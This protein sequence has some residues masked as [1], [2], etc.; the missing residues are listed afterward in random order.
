MTEEEARKKWCPMARCS[1][2]EGRG[3]FNRDDFKLNIMESCLASDC[4]K[5]PECK[6]WWDKTKQGKVK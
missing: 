4:M 1:V 6:S 2:F 5:W 3:V